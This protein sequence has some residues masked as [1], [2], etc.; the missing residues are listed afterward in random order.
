MGKIKTI[1]FTLFGSMCLAQTSLAEDWIYSTVEGDSLW[2]ISERHLD[3]V[4][5]YA[6]L[7]KINGIKV[8]KKMQ[9]GTKIRIPMKWITSNPV[10][11]KIK[12]IEGAADLIRADGSVMENVKPETLIY[13][14]D[15]LKSRKNASVAI[16]FAD[17]SILTLYSNSTI[18]FDHL[19]AHGTTGMVDSRLHLLEGRLDTR[20]KSAVGPG[21]RFEIQTP[22]AISAVRGTEYRTLVKAE[23]NISNIEVLRG[24]VAVTGADKQELIKAGFGTKVAVG[25]A[26]IKARKLLSPPTLDSFAD[27]VRYIN[28]IITWGSLKDANKYRFEFASDP[29]FNT[30]LWEQYSQYARAALPDLPDGRY[31][32]RVR[33]VDELG[34]EGKNTVKTVNLNA[35]PQA[36]VQLQPSEDRVLRGETPKLLWTASSEAEKYRLEIATDKDFT[37]PLFTSNELSKT[38]FDT[39]EF[40]QVG[41]YY[42]RLSSIA[43]DGEIGPVG[44]TRHYEIKHKPEK[45]EATMAKA[46]D[47][48]LIATWHAG[49]S[50]QTYQVQLANDES[51]TQLDQD[52][53][54]S[55]PR[56]SFDPI[57]GQVRYLRVRAIEPDGYLGPWGATQRVDP[58]PDDTLWWVPAL[59]VIGILLL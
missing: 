33:G 9:P 46:D 12:S 18:R 26:P 14:G 32:M 20:V 30:I 56:L 4:T 27:P 23:D 58:L 51:F 55:T 11:A 43:A 31:Y 59:S 54:T 35:R 16:Q 5:R 15:R 29:E 13:L 28:S 53:K 24:K 42:W 8:P 48:K 52:I 34:L 2:N 1:C 3:K 57:S 47:G 50:D 25:T 37:Q 45:V 44:T 21:S 49:R 38:S 7:K 36:P 10:P 41:N 19:T 40:S 17:K 39:G 22:S 6:Q